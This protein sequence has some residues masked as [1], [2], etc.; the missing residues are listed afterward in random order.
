M[1]LEDKIHKEWM[2][3]DFGFEKDKIEDSV[4][5]KVPVRY[6]PPMTT[7]QKAEL[8]YYEETKVVEFIKKENSNQII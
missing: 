3:Q 5:L 6:N 8:S 7:E 4:L 2:E 1:N